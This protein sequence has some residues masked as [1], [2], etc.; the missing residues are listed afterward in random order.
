MQG[1]SE[2][3][4]ATTWSDSIPPAEP[5]IRVRQATGSDSD[6]LRELL[7]ELFEERPD[8]AQLA[9]HL[10]PLG[11][12]APGLLIAEAGGRPVGAAARG[13][14]YWGDVGERVPLLLRVAEGA[15][16]RGVGSI[17]LERLRED[18]R[19][20]GVTSLEVTQPTEP[21]AVAFLREQ[22]FSRDLEQASFDVDL[23]DFRAHVATLC[24]RIA[25]RRTLPDGLSL[26]PLPD[27]PDAS[28][29][30]LFHVVLG[31]KGDDF[32]TWLLSEDYRALRDLSV[33][34]RVNDRAVGVLL[35]FRKGPHVHA[36]YEEILPDMRRTG[37]H[38]LLLSA[39]AERAAEQGATRTWFDTNCHLSGYRH[40]LRLAERLGAEPIAC[41]A[42]HVLELEPTA[43]G[44]SDGAARL[45]VVPSPAAMSPSPVSG[46]QPLLVGQEAETTWDAIARL[47]DELVSE[48]DVS[49]DAG[50]V[51]A[52]LAT[53][54]AGRALCHLELARAGIDSAHDDLASRWLDVALEAVAERP[55]GIGL[56]DGFTGVA[57]VASRFSEA[58]LHEADGLE[59]V[60][61]TLADT[62]ASQAW[63]GR[64]DLRGGLV[65]IG[66]HALERR[67]RASA[68]S[69][70]EDVIERLDQASLV[71]GSRDWSLA[72]MRHAPEAPHVFRG[73]RRDLG[74]LHGMAGVVALLS[75][76]CAL[77]E[78][79]GSARELLFESIEWLLDR[80]LPPGS[81]SR[82]PSFV[83]W[84][85]PTPSRP[86][87]CSGD[88]GIALALLSAARS[89]GESSWEILALDIALHA[90]TRSAESAGID[91]ASAC[92]GAIGVA[93]ALNRLH[94]A[95][96][97]PSLEQAARTWL[98]HAVTLAL[99]TDDTPPRLSGNGLLDG[100]SG[101]VLGLLSAVSL[102]EPTW[103]EALLMPIAPSA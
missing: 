99:P 33:V 76:A 83:G 59:D 98:D 26:G 66:V 74:V 94:R 31:R 30:S 38:A 40:T 49:V 19:A 67:S 90:A 14:R 85:T 70:I 23:G 93:Q 69:L 82:F 63:T 20:A 56:H 89:I 47:S 32:R 96:G 9:E 27:D 68:R 55:L 13:V 43:R 87:W 17:L 81:A 71:N 3:Q 97:H 24:E 102:D 1:R 80:E 103:D 21:G 92:H 62:L 25:R 61:A 18:G 50:S 51:D 57:W 53:G 91:T 84:A 4:A 77:D 95:L 8:W 48:P 28:L 10:G 34:A 15:R 75:R 101:V 65:G 12:W 36:E 78:P 16:R 7:P 72:L 79:P 60:D 45:D 86:S 2:T 6:V 54:A 39:V 52:S 22:G 29:E 73:G 46:W 44:P 100:R 35:A 5:G 41:R 88:L 58:S 37:I 11:P 42:F 64:L